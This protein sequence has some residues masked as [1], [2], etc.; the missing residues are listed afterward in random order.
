MKSR[1]HTLQLALGSPAPARPR[2]LEHSDFKFFIHNT[3]TSS[4]TTPGSFQKFFFIPSNPKWWYDIFLLRNSLLGQPSVLF[5]LNL[6]PFCSGRF[7]LWCHGF[8]PFFSTTFPA[9]SLYSFSA[10]G[11]GTP[12][13]HLCSS[14]LPQPW[15]RLRC[16]VSVLCNLS[17]TLSFNLTNEVFIFIV[18]FL[19]P[20]FTLFSASCIICFF[21]TLFFYLFSFISLSDI[22]GCPHLWFILKTQTTKSWVQAACVWKSSSSRCLHGVVDANPCFPMTGTPNVSSQLSR[23]QAANTRA[24]G[25]IRPS[26][27]FYLAWHLVST[28]RQHRDLA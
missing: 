2:V 17:S 9:R 16:P 23:A 14:L 21:G 1:P 26:T 15:L 19:Y 12:G 4:P 13:P 6:L 22:E 18:N 28:R 8:D 7:L 27:L 10:A 11:A 24:A 20:S 3:Y 5:Q 25:W